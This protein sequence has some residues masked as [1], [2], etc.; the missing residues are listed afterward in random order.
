D[1]KADNLELGDPSEH[2]AAVDAKNLDLKVADPPGGMLPESGGQGYL[3]F[4]GLGLIILI[5][6]A[7]VA[8]RSFN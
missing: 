7:F 5:I 1:A 6:G 4:V 8:R 3:P 2:T